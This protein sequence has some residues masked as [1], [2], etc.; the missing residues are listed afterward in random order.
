MFY[1]QL[2]DCRQSKDVFEKSEVVLLARQ[3]E[4]KV[5]YIL[6]KGRQTE[7]SA[8]GND[9]E[10]S[11]PPIFVSKISQKQEQSNVRPPSVYAKIVEKQNEKQDENV[12]VEQQITEQRLDALVDKPSAPSKAKVNLRMKLEQIKKAVKLDQKKSCETPSVDGDSATEKVE[13]TAE[14][15]CETTESEIIDVESSHS[16]DPDFLQVKELHSVQHFQ[17]MPLQLEVA[18][19]T[20]HLTFLCSRLVFL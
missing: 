4:D 1:L 12:K 20:F 11:L 2:T 17:P 18:K 19:V 9:Q 16:T 6:W 15:V 3:V 14:Y 8:K 7:T 13:E 10:L 5:P